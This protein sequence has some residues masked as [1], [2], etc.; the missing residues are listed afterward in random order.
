MH[1]AALN[2]YPVK[3]L[4]G[5]YAARVAL[6]ELGLVGDRRFMVVDENDRFLSQRTLPR[7]ALLQTRLDSDTLTLSAK[8]LGSQLQVQRASDP[9]AHLRRVSVWSSEGLHAEDCGDVAA[10]WLQQFLEVRCR[11]VRAGSAFNRPILKGGR[12]NELMNFADASPFLA[13]S[14]ASLGMLNDGLILHGE[15]PVPMDRFRP[16]L[17]F[18]DTAPFAED[19]WARIRIGDIILRSTGPCARCV[20]TTTNQQ[21]AIR[22]PEPLRTL[23]TFRRDVSN[24][25]DVNFGQN[26]VHETKSGTLAVGAKIDVLEYRSGIA[27]HS[28]EACH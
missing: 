18:A 6:D 17:V 13:V 25:T 26:L 20:V 16:N 11:L 28:P 12:E 10:R 9:A 23:A 7:M 2:L 21:T 3:S 22:G 24:P 19:S 14:E 15:E 4:A 8:T 27:T 1:L 5:M